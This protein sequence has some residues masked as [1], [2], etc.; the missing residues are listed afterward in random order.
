M[1]DKPTD[2][3]ID[4]PNYFVAMEKTNNSIC[5]C[6]V[7]YYGFS[8]YPCSDPAPI[9]VNIPKNCLKCGKP[10]KTKN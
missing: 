7:Y 3:S 2:K 6:G 8:L 9:M 5:T 1:T 10:Y 4:N